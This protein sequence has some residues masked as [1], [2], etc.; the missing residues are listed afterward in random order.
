MSSSALHPDLLVHRFQLRSQLYVPELRLDQSVLQPP[1]EP[2]IIGLTAQNLYRGEHGIVP[3]E[4]IGCWH[5]GAA[6]RSRT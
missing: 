4:S 5:G 2:L 1:A 3:A 6:I